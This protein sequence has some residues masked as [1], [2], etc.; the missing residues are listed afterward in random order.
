MRSNFYLFFQIL[1]MSWS[2]GNEI[3]HSIKRIFEKM[4]N[5]ELLSKYSFHGIRN[6]KSFSSLNICSTIFGKILYKV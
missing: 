2:M 3:K 5:D 6:K 4:F 1:E